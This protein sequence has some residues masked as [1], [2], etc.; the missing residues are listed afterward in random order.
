MKPDIH[1]PLILVGKKAAG[2]ILTQQE[3][4]RHQQQKQNKGYIRLVDQVPAGA[5]YP[6]VARPNTRLNQRKNAPTGPRDSFF[7]RNKTAA[8]AGL[9][10]NALKADKATE[11]AMVTANC[12]YNRPVIPGMKAVGINT[13]ARIRAMAITGPETSS[14]ARNAAS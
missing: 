7:G 11:T 1:K 10:V 13:A 14:I 5:T 6:S 9:R 8:R 4:A 2:D 12:W 3:G